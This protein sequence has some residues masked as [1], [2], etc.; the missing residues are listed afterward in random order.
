MKEAIFVAPIAGLLF[1][2]LAITARVLKKSWLTPGAFFALYWCVV[3]V[4][5]LIFSPNEEVSIWAVFWIFVSA[6]TVFAGDLVGA[7]GRKN[8]KQ[9]KENVVFSSMQI[10]LISAV[11]V[12]C[13][14][15]GLVS[16]IIVFANAT[17]A[18]GASLSIQD[19][20]AVA[21]KIEGSRYTKIYKPFLTQ[22]LNMFLYAGPLFGGLLVAM[23]SRLRYLVMAALSLLP[24][25]LMTTI[26]MLRGFIIISI[27]LGISSFL[28]TRVLLGHNQLF[29][30]RFVISGLAVAVLLAV[31]VIGAGFIRKS[32][33]DTRSIAVHSYVQIRNAAF[34]HIAVFSDWFKKNGLKLKTPSPGF[35][36]FGG[37]FDLLGIRKR[38]VGLFT[39]TVVLSNGETSNIYTIFR[40]LIEDF[41]PVGSLII[42]FFVGF[43]T[44]RVYLLIVQGRIRT[45]PILV[46]FYATVLWSFVTCIWIWNSIIAAFVFFTIGFIVILSLPN[47]K[48]TLSYFYSHLL[49]IISFS[50]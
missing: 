28:A 42:L 41:T 18:L 14:V 29:T 43:F 26:F 23:D 4:L 25:M 33:S 47:L 48:E 1:I 22:F 11:V 6:L 37:V 7:L 19:F 9:M 17:Q 32:T 45:M 12:F 8:R 10:S 20:I 40:V 31:I 21:R 2:P 5:P 44:S 38:E 34:P 50:R 49:R 30:R 13:S 24:A 35:Y 39:E 36:A 15:V 3:T 16:F 27:L 46:A